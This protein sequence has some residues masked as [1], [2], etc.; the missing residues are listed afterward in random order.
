MIVEK[1]FLK[2]LFRIIFW[3][4]IQPTVRMLPFSSINGIGETLGY[5]DYI[6]SGR[7]RV[8]KM[9]KNISSAFGDMGRKEEKIIKRNLQNHLRNTLELAKYPQ[10]NRQRITPFVRYEGIN[11]LNNAL[12]KRGKGVIL[13]TA[14]FGAKQFLQIALGLYGYTLNQINYNLG[15]EEL[16]YIQRRVSQSQRIDIEKQIPVTFISAKGFLRNAFNCLKNNEILIVA[17][18][19]I[20]LQN[21]MDRSYQPFDFLGK[22]MLFP[23]NPV[24]LAKKTGAEIIPVFVVRKKRYH[25]IV[26]EP[27][28][29]INKKEKNAAVKEYVNILEKYVRRYPDHWEFWEEFDEDNL[30]VS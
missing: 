25:T 22:K 5:I 4:L 16:S 18:D 21:H 12:Q 17:G 11:Y 9:T 26:F 28:I 24:V 2:D 6:V 15:K 19:G 29:N 10:F 27:P 8:L 14:H 3:F 30:L 20:G 1:K 13:L 7:K 23:T